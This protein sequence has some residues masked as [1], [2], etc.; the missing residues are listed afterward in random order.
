MYFLGLCPENSGFYKKIFLDT[1]VNSCSLHILSITKMV[2]QVRVDSYTLGGQAKGY[3]NYLYTI[4][5]NIY[6]KHGLLFLIFKYNFK[7]NT[8]SNIKGLKYF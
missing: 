4:S 3:S 7:F 1:Q 8:F 6:V 2:S 5:L